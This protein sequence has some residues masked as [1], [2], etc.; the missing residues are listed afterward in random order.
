MSKVIRHAPTSFGKPIFAKKIFLIILPEKIGNMRDHITTCR[1]PSYAV[2]S[3]FQLRPISKANVFP[4]KLMQ[5]SGGIRIGIHAT[6]MSSGQRHQSASSACTRTRDRRS[7]AWMG[8]SFSNKFSLPREGST[9][10]TSFARVLITYCTILQSSEPL[11]RKFGQSEFRTLCR[12]LATLHKWLLSHLAQWL[13][14]QQ[15][16]CH[17]TGPRFFS[18]ELP[19]LHR[20]ALTRTDT[21]SDQ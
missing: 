13:L 4:T 2:L 12:I 18:A 11:H 3:R 16:S 14:L 21:R 8:S 9:S 17:L 19:T 5:I 7:V 6:A 1:A 10:Q 20:A 15:P